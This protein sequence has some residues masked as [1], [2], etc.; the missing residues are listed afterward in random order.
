MPKML[1]VPT[2]ASRLYRN[3]PSALMVMSRFVA[4]VGFVPTTVPGNAVSAPLLPMV[5]PEI[6]EEPALEV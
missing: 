2:F 5:K 6:V 4:P 1:I 3:L